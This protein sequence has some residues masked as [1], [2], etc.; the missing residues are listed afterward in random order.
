MLQM[1][2]NFIFNIILTIVQAITTPF[3]S[4]LFALFP[5]VAQYFSYITTFFTTS[6][7]YVT[8]ILRWFLFEPAMLTLLFDYYIIKYTV[9]LTIQAVK[10]TINL[11]DK[12]KP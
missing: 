3:M 5:D 10:F 2:I 7:T 11:Y 1:L 4:V 9:H 12:L 8:T 6:I